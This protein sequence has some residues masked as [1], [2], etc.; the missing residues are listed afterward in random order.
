MDNL[1]IYSAIAGEPVGVYDR[2]LRD[3][4]KYPR[5]CML[6]DGEEVV[7]FVKSTQGDLLEVDQ[8]DGKLYRTGNTVSVEN[9]V[10]RYNIA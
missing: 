3:L 4:R 8:L 10:V 7:L 9:G 2:Y 6:K 1:D 5:L